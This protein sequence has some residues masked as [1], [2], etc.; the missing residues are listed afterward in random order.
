MKQIRNQL[1]TAQV[2]LASEALF[3]YANERKGQ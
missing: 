1:A 3:P 2:F